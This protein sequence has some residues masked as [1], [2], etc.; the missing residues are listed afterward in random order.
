MKCLECNKDFKSISNTHL[1]KCCGLTIKEYAIKHCIPIEVLFS[2]ANRQSLKLTS[3]QME[4]ANKKRSNTARNKQ[5][6][7]LTYEES[8]VIVGS[9]LGD[10][11]IFRG[12]NS[13]KTTYL[14]L[15]QGIKQL[16]YL[17]WKGLKLKRLE[18]KFYQYYAYSP[19]KKRYS[20]INQ[21]RTPS[22][23]MIGDLIPHLYSPTGGKFIDPEFLEY[24][25]PLALAIWFMD[26][27]SKGPSGGTL[28]TQSFSTSD[29]IIIRDFLK[30]KFNIE[31]SVHFDTKDMPFIY[32]N[33]KGFD[34]LIEIIE[35]HMFYQMMY[36]LGKTDLPECTLSK[37]VIFDACHFLD[38]Y[39]G[40]CA[41]LHGGRY[42]LWVSVK[43]PVDPSTG[44][45]LDY[46]Y[47]KTIL[48]RYIV[49]LFD[50]NCLNYQV[51]NLGW[52]STTELIC[53]FI[54]KTLIEFFP[55]LSKLELFETEGSKCEYIGPS[56]D[57]MK[58]DKTL[59]ILT[60][61]TEKDIIWR[62]RIITEFGDMFNNVDDHIEE[63][64]DVNIE[65]LTEDPKSIKLI[66][67]SELL[68]KLPKNMRE[69]GGL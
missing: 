56:L 11:Y 41:N 46:G 4:E 20:T 32:F 45:V 42:E 27:G 3:E 48:D 54:W 64:E 58:K 17:W 53:M 34:R 68:T 13:Q 1:L 39:D 7:T 16:N 47:M 12:K 8:Q 37:R 25:D 31:S 49:N 44:M 67:L 59:D 65:I 30:T 61:F 60:L 24:V 66:K 23:Y 21:V 29:N 26:D 36:K 5:T 40:K 22:M 15:E 38:E 57:E 6:A 35:P 18:P 2:K 33:K 51:N 62:E 10:G 55:T 14:I 52:R 28:A 19:V 69:I 43:G 9:L 50:H 63:S